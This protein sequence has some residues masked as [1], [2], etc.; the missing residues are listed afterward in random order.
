MVAGGLL[1]QHLPEGE[2]GRDRLHTRL[3]HPDWP[4]VAIL[5]G[6]VKAG[7]LTDPDLPLDDLLWRL[8]HEEDEVRTLPRFARQGLPL[9]S[10]L[11]ALGDR[12]LPAEER[13]AMV[14]DDGFIRVDCAF[15]SSSFPIPAVGRARFDGLRRAWRARRV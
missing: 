5:A 10:R 8:F 15:C 11:C 12:P 14:G 4:H 9:R 3:D 1:F 2:E 7:E 13:A 6:S